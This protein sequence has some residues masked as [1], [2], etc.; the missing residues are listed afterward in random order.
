ME[1]A[2]LFYLLI[3]FGTPQKVSL[4]KKKQTDMIA[5]N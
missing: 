5:V 3:C 2:G 1:N 4:K